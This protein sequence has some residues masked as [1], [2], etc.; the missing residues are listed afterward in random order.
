[1]SLSFATQISELLAQTEPFDSLSEEDRLVLRQ[2]ITLEIYAPGEV[3]LDQGD[4][5]HR[6]LYVVVEG[7]VRLSE[8]D[9]RLIQASEG[10]AQVGELVDDPADGTLHLLGVSCKTE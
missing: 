10:G 5:I 4:D 8:A 7:L 9:P 6:A 3:I 1:M 2:K